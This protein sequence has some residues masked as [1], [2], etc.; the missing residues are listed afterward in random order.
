MSIRSL[1]TA[2]ILAYFGL[3]YLLPLVL[4]EPLGPHT[5]LR[6]EG[7]ALLTGSVVLSVLALAFLFARSGIRLPTAWA[8]RLPNIFEYEYLMLALVLLSLPV[9]WRFH[10]QFGVGF[11]YSGVGLANAG[12]VAQYMFLFK[13]FFFAFILYSFVCFLRGRRFS[14][15]TR[16]VM[17]LS[18]V[19]WGLSANGSADIIWLAVA[20]CMA[21]FGNSARH[22]FVSSKR[23]GTGALRQMLRD[24][25]LI[26]VLLGVAF[27]IVLFGFANKSDVE[28]ALARFTADNLSSVVYYLYYRV[29]MFVASI[30]STLSYGFDWQFYARSIDVLGDMIGYRVRTIMGLE[31]IRPDLAGLNQL[32]YFEIYRYPSNMRSGASPGVIGSF[33]YLPFLPLNLILCSFYIA[34]VKNTYD[35]AASLGKSERLTVFTM[36][37]MIFASFTLLH[38][39]FESFLKVGPELL[40]ALMILYALEKARCVDGERDRVTEPALRSPTGLP[41]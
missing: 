27:G 9:S 35:R 30:E 16:L 31:V 15:M 12:F 18:S 3:F 26:V 32:N 39:P 17:L 6:Y 5:A 41:A 1:G 14:R 13:S 24:S 33:L 34:A 23:Q 2:S 25:S 22:F 11:R 20:L 10:S 28:S 40:T 36:F 7:D 37:F 4:M 19:V 38:S 21:V 8:R 29:S